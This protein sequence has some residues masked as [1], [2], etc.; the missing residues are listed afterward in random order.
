MKRFIANTIVFLSGVA[1]LMSVIVTEISTL[2]R[3][4]EQGPIIVLAL[5]GALLCWC[6]T[7]LI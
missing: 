6:A 7:E 5:Y 1:I 2:S 4:I 3:H